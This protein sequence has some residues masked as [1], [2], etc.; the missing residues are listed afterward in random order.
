MPMPGSKTLPPVKAHDGER[1]PTW[2]GRHARPCS[3]RI[4]SDLAAVRYSSSVSSAF[5]VAHRCPRKPCRS[6]PSVPRNAPFR[7][8]QPMYFARICLLGTGSRAGLSAISC[9]ADGSPQG[10]R[11]PLPSGLV[12]HQASPGSMV[13]FCALDGHVG[14][15]GQVVRRL[16]VL[17]SSPASETRAFAPDDFLG[18]PLVRQAR[19]APSA[20]FGLSRQHLLQQRGAP[21]ALSP[22]RTASSF[23]ERRS[24]MNIFGACSLVARRGRAPSNSSGFLGLGDQPT[25]VE[26]SASAR[27]SCCDRSMPRASLISAAVEPRAGIS[28]T[29]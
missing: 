14:T 23:P 8:S 15:C 24:S 29:A 13:K 7:P 18:L 6:R 5:E 12:L 1:L 4:G 20:F 3:G 25:F 21:P 28:A 2:N 17:T 22:G 10:C 16:R 27:T 19:L 26:Q 11:G 9:L